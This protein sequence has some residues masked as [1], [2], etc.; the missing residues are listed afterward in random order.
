MELQDTARIAWLSLQVSLLATLTIAPAAVALGYLFSRVRFPGRAILR[1]ARMLPMVLPPVAVGF[2]LLQLLSTNHA[3]GA[4][5]ETLLGGPL[6]LTPKACVLAAAVMAF[7][8]AALGAERGFDA[9]P[10]RLEQVAATLGTRPRRVFAT[11]TLPLAGRGILHG[12]VFAFVR[13]LGEFGATAVV[14]G[15]VPGETETLPMAIF[16]RFE[17][18]RDRDAL[19]LSALSVLFAFSVTAAAERFLGRGPLT[20]REREAA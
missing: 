15:N 7:P 11:V 19:L 5:L 18:Y 3:F 10:R 14:A 16:A 17:D 1:T 12:L 13:A 9:V 2:L 4:A 6:L 20:A 8:L